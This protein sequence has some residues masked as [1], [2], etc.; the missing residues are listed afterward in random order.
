[1]SYIVT[2]SKI[3]FHSNVDYHFKLHRDECCFPERCYDEQGFI[4]VTVIMLTVAMQSVITISAERYYIGLLSDP[5]NYT[6]CCYAECHYTKC[7]YAERQ[8]HLASLWPM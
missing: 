1:V 6:E 8:L 5:C 2:L 4:V 7:C 3:V